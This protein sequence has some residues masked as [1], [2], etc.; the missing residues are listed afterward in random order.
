[1]LWGCITW[2]GVGFVHRIDG[3]MNAAMYTS[4]LD[5]ALTRSLEHHDL[6]TDDIIFQQDNDPK[7]TS[8]LAREYFAEHGIDVMEWSAQSPDLNPIEHVWQNF[9]RAL[10]MPTMPPSGMA[11]LWERIVEEWNAIPATAI[12]ELI[13]SM[14]ARCQAVIDAN[15]GHT[16]Y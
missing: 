6:S 14:P 1:M 2:D 11:D 12:R 8:R 16:K 15:G 13:S 9:K 10:N 3:N 7:H 5:A 4:I